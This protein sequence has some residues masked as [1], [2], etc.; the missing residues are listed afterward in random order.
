M[1]IVAPHMAVDEE[2]LQ[3]IREMSEDTGD[4]VVAKGAADLLAIFASTE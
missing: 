3:M 1:R 2:A 4:V